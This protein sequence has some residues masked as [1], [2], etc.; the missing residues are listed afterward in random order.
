MNLNLGI[1]FYVANNL[2]LSET[3]LS[4]LEEISLN[5]RILAESDVKGLALSYSKSKYNLHS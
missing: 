3:K 4:Y 2:L 5:Q 1:E